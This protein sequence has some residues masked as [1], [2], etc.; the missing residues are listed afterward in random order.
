MQIVAVGE[1]RTLVGTK[2]KSRN[3]EITLSHVVPDIVQNFLSGQSPLHQI[4]D[5]Q[6]FRHFTYDGNLARGIVTV[7]QH[8]DAISEDFNLSCSDSTTVMCLAKKVEEEI[9]GNEPFRATFDDQ[10]E[11]EVQKPISYVLKAKKALGF[12]AITSLHV[13]LDEVI[14]CISRPKNK[15]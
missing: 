1:S 13:I 2:F 5:G 14:P 4:G 9:E 15:I 11:H 3:L 7:W 12:E 8:P 10:Y 6:Q